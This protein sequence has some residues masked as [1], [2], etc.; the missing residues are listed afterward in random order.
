M[1]LTC[2]VS[3][4][5]SNALFFHEWHATRRHKALAIFPGIAFPQFWLVSRRSQLMSAL[6]CVA[7]GTFADRRGPAAAA[8]RR[9]RPRGCRTDNDVS[10]R[11]AAPH[12][13]VRPCLHGRATQPMARAA[14]ARRGGRGPSLGDNSTLH[15][16]GRAGRPGVDVWSRRPAGQ[17]GP[18]QPLYQTRP[19]RHSRHRNTGCRQS[20]PSKMSNSTPLGTK[21]HD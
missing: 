13:P 11:P 4:R 3:C 1:T 12:G 18:P 10:R 2:S 9:A 7:A 16:P 6:C 15:R 5:P 14:P 19:A 17:M 20:R 21:Q 8:G